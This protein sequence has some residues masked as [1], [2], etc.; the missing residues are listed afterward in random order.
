MILLLIAGIACLI[1][2]YALYII[3]EKKHREQ[4]ADQAVGRKKILMLDA[5]DDEEIIITPGR[6]TRPP[7]AAIVCLVAGSLCLVLFWIFRP[8][9][10][11]HTMTISHEQ[12][13]VKRLTAHLD[14]YF[15]GS[16]KTYP[17]KAAV[18]VH[19]AQ[20]YYKSRLIGRIRD[21][22][23][24]DLF[25]LQVISATD[26]PQFFGTDVESLTLAQFTAIVKAFPDLD[27]VILLVNLDNIY[28]DPWRAG[29]RPY[30]AVFFDEARFNDSVY[31]LNNG[32]IDLAAVSK[33]TYQN[34]ALIPL[35]ELPDVLFDR[36]FLLI[37]AGNAATIVETYRQGIVPAP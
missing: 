35:S 36:H 12:L 27:L 13:A 15:R 23:S 29:R 20:T 17:V 26:N 24:T 4:A 28:G 10:Q 30:T 37:N 19:D 34:H 1:A 18:V 2:S 7:V 25:A 22:L 3:H 14:H 33:G 32:Y 21:Q 9:K 31:L 8:A 5:E 16:G 11:L 6:K